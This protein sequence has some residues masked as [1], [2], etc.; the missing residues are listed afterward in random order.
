MKKTTRKAPK[1]PEPFLM[2]WPPSRGP[3]PKWMTTPP[4][5]VFD[6]PT[7]ERLDDAKYTPPE[8][9]KV[10]IKAP[11]RSKTS[12]GIGKE[13]FQKDLEQK[14]NAQVAWNARVLVPIE[15][16]LGVT[17]EQACDLVHGIDHKLHR[18]K[19]Q[20]APPIPVREFV[21]DLYY[22]LEKVARVRIRP[23]VAFY[24][25]RSGGWG[26]SS[27]RMDLGYVLWQLARAYKKIYKRHKEFGIWGHAIGD[28]VFE[29]VEIKHNVLRVFVG[30]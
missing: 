24:L 17:L 16:L 6:E 30:S 13:I 25:R 15:T 21:C 3:Q 23:Y 18:G 10:R 11:P 27:P 22:P 19:P 26:K 1:K 12:F 8:I 5:H 9:V 4:R 29:S 28:L 14:A 2:N 20:W 7:I